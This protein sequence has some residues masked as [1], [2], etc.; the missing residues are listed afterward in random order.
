MNITVT[1][2][3]K[4]VPITI[5]EVIGDIDG[6][7]FKD[8]IAKG[9]EAVHRGT[10]AMLLDL[11]QVNYVSSAGLL[12][13][14]TIAALLSKET[15]PDPDAGWQSLH[16]MEGATM[17]KPALLKLLNPQPRV[18][19]ALSLVGFDRFIEIYTDREVALASF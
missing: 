11:N 19:R 18:Q 8:L 4:R 12:A 5:V 15:P 3:T 10:N 16:R 13:I 14:Q 9:S 1:E 2:V 7:N 17:S 6:S